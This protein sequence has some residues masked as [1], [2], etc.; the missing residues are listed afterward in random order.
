MTAEQVRSATRLLALGRV[1]LGVTAMVAPTLPSRPWVGGDATRPTIKLFAR[2]LGA[3]DLA[4]G[5]GGVLAFRRGAPV[6][7]WGGSRRSLRR[8]RRRRHHY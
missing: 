3:R 4:I 1:A 6:R 5:L 2:S 8:R 7:G